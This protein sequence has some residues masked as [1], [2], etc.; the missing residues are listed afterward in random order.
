MTS[1]IKIDYNITNAQNNNATFG[2]YK[3]SDFNGGANARNMTYA[4]MVGINFKFKDPNDMVAPS[5]K[6]RRKSFGKKK[7]Y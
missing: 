1:A 3:V 2:S 5:N 6:F 4:L 7:R